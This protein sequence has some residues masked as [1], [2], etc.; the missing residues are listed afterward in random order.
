MAVEWE[1]GVTAE[2]FDARPPYAASVVTE[3]R[4]RMALPPE[5]RVCDV[6]AGTG[7]LTRALATD[8]GAII[9]LEPSAAM[10]AKGT[11]GTRDRPAVT[12]IG[13]V[14]EA[15][16]FAPAAFALVS[17]GSS[18]NVVERVAALREAARVLVPGGWLLCLWNHRRLE[19]PLQAEIEAAIR[20]HVPGYA[21]GVR[22]EDQ[23]PII[24]A[25]GRFTPSEHLEAACVHRVRT[26]Q[27]L[28]AWQTHLTLRRQAGARF[29][30]VLAAIAALAHGAGETI[31]VP[32]VTRAWLARRI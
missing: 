25:S 32:Y 16:P 11:A 28:Q 29:D 26:A 13:G 4:A 3:A 1:Y 23:A 5:A 20:A 24:A 7:R 31:A 22:R 8:G 18:F 14:A 27:W 6:G 12:W 17:F 10:R 19:D 21:H 15:L 2:C 30:G 9:A